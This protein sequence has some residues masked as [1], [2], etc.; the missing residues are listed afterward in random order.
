MSVLALVGALRD[1]ATTNRRI[2]RAAATVGV[3]SIGVKLIAMFKEVAV[4][5]YF[6]RSGPVD[7]FLA[8]YLLPGFVVVLVGGS[9][10]AAFIP[11]FIQVRKDGGEGAGQRLFSSCMVWS[12]GLLLGLTLLLAAVG[13]SL[14]R[15]IASG[16][17]PQKLQLCTHLF[18]AMLPMILLSG[19]A[20]NSSAILNAS[21]CFWLPAVCPVLTPLLTFILLLT[22]A[23]TWGVWSLVGGVLLGSL[24]ECVV[25]GF[26]LHYKRI[27][28]WPRWH[29][30]TRE[31]RQ[32]GVQYIPLLIG[33]VLVSG[34]TVVDQSMAAWLQP[35]SVA[36]LAYGNRMV[37]VVVGLTATSLS[38]A[39]IPYFSEMIAEGNWEACRHTLQTYTRILLLAMTPIGILLV[40]FSPVLVRWLFQRGAFT[41]QDTLVVSRVQ[42]MYALQIPF[43]AAGLLYVRMLTA[44]RRNDLVMISAGISLS[45]DI[46]LNLICM[47]F[48]GVA[49]IALSTSLFY[50]ASLLFAFLTARYL[51]A[52]RI[53]SQNRTR[54]SL[55]TKAR[56][57][58]ISLQRNGINGGTRAEPAQQ[59]K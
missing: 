17:S 48:F 15:A 36:A 34:V 52:E 41:A 29:G 39:V 30:Y 25:L 27:H 18:Y 35:G 33:S 21:K 12:Q 26:A 2:F 43:Y 8:A 56:S 10:N 49:G 42:A 57:A 20:A 16:F 4:A 59:L 50:V 3:F 44:M 24:A 54:N 19:V 51:L 31:V 7:A 47:R 46:V 28:L 55:E 22:R 38:A 45:L 32:V 37:S 5:N 11:T 14:V 1:P 53:A 6:G 13:P 58:S 23:K 40:V 9:L